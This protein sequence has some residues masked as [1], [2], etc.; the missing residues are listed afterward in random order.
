MRYVCE[1]YGVGV[2]DVC[3]GEY[4]YDMQCEMCMCACVI[5]MSVCL[6]CML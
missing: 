5:C 2:Y 3:E 4:M 1:I 6:G